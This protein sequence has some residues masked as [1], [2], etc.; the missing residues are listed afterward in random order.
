MNKSFF[1]SLGSFCSLNERNDSK[2][3]SFILMN[4]R[5]QESHERAKHNKKM[6]YDVQINYVGQFLRSTYI[7]L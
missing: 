2:K 5:E 6:A 1:E 7:C 3:D 4:E